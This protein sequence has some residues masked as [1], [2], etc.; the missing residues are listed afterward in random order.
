MFNDPL[1]GSLTQITPSLTAPQPLQP[2]LI[3]VRLFELLDAGLTVSFPGAPQTNIPS[4]ALQLDLGV[5]QVVGVG[6][7]G[8]APLELFGAIELQVPQL[9]EIQL[10]L[11]A[12][13]DSRANI[14][15]RPRKS[16]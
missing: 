8:L 7:G 1:L 4:N 14:P 13:A 12:P 5:L 15:H 6:G 2:D 9:F 16:G 3:N 11:G 10:E